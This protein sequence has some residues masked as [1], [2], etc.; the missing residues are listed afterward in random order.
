MTFLCVTDMMLLLTIISLLSSISSGA[1]LIRFSDT[2]SILRTRWWWPYACFFVNFFF[3][4]IN[5]TVRNLYVSYPNTSNSSIFYFVLKALYSMD[6]DV[7]AKVTAT[8]KYTEIPTERN[9]WHTPSKSFLNCMILYVLNFYAV[10]CSSWFVVMY[11]L[12]FFI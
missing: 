4:I 11:C 7:P 10:V 5:R 6:K 3:P 9:Y 8:V 12:C 2:F 1:V